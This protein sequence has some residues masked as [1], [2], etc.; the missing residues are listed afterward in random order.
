[1]LQKHKLSKES[2]LRQACSLIV[3]L[4]D[5][6]ACS[7]IV[8][9]PERQACSLIVELPEHAIENKLVLTI[10]GL[11]LNCRAAWQA[12]SLIVELP[13]IHASEK[14]SCQGSELQ[15]HTLCRRYHTGILFLSKVI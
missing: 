4:P 11:L 15:I 1:M 7:L 2:G 6:Q 9:L 10:Q 13:E 14:I 3:E 12:C 5:R 8:E